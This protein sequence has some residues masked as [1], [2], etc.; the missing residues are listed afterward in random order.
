MSTDKPKVDASKCPRR[1]PAFW[2]NSNDSTPGS[3]LDPKGLP[4]SP[5]C[6]AG[7]GRGHPKKNQ[8]GEATK[9]GWP[10]SD[11]AKAELVS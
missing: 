4:A 9:L 7:P 8:V 5:R 2:A 10:F 1:A 6:A 11:P 3:N